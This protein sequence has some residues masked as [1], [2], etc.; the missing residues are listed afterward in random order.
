[1]S[2][3]SL[4]D[5]K[6]TLQVLAGLYKNPNLF[7]RYDKYSLSWQDF[8]I[9]IHRIVF[10]A[11]HN[12]TMQGIRNPSVVDIEN[13]LFARAQIKEIYDKEN[14]AQ[15]LEHL[16]ALADLSKFDYYYNRMKKFS[17]LAS[18]Y[19]NGIDISTIYNKD[20]IDPALK[21]KQED[22]IDNL[23][24]DELVSIINNKIEE[25]TK[26][27]LGNT[28][29]ETKQIGE[30]LSDLIESY[31]S[32]PEIGIPL[33]G[34]L[35]NSITRGARLK[36]FY[37][38]SAPTGVGKT[39]MMMADICNFAT[40]KIFD[41]TKNTWVENG[42]SEPSLFITTE[43]EIDECQTM[44]LAFLS[45]VQEEKILNGTYD[46]YEQKRLSQAAKTLEKSPLWIEHLP[47]FSLRDIESVIRR[48]VRE[49]G[50]RYIAFD[51]LHTSL[52]ILEEI[53]QKAKGI[54]L[55]EDN[56]LFMIA[57]K[58]KDLCNELGVFILSGTQLN[59]DWENRGTSNQNVLRGAKAIA[60]KIDL[61]II[62]VPVTDEDRESL[63]NFVTA[64]VL[65]MP[66]LV[67]HIYKNRR[68][69]FKS[70]KLW[71]SADLGI[72]RVTPLFLTDD[73]YNLIEIEDLDIIVENEIDLTK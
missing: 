5:N 20:I 33:Y 13:Y 42:T 47:N 48:H 51:Y 27:L 8:N 31:K 66:N 56:I 21:R 22:Y 4:Y 64:N 45:G 10:N 23:S 69:K 60:D 24:I 2:N 46:P 6:S 38:R 35:I 30:G 41:L 7:D 37:L 14:G 71:C 26:S 19:D 28:I 18:F 34:P 44:A 62:S 67:H 16:E 11:L 61:G 54:A 70:V 39:R 65:P 52:R 43:L 32:Q 72:C 49:N 29:S 15:F 17:L 57:I 63:K 12:L 68:G 53:S 25:I 55:R 36:K 9:P 1:M 58:I 40:D 50:V 3:A 73:N 59:A